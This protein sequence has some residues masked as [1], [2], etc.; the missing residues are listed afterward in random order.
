MFSTTYFISSNPL[1]VKVITKSLLFAANRIS[2]WIR[3]SGVR[4]LSGQPGMKIFSQISFS[5]SKVSI[6][7]L[8]KVW[9]T[10]GTERSV[11]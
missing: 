6:G 2:K 5:L 11:V 3:F 7:Y 10:L 8:V 9:V 1:M 4:D